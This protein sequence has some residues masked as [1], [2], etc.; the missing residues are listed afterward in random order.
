MYYRKSS[1]KSWGRGYLFFVVYE[2]GLINRG[3]AR[4]GG[5]ISNAK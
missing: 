1:I 2:G 3:L 4:E 5:L